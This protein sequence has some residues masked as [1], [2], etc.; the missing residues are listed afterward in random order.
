M[1][2][3]GTHPISIMECRGILYYWVSFNFR[4]GEEE[5]ASVGVVHIGRFPPIFVNHSVP[6]NNSQIARIPNSAADEIPLWTLQPG[7]IK[8]LF[9]VIAIE[10]Q[11]EGDTRSTRCSASK[12]MQGW[13]SPARWLDI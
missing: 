8:L 2:P 3:Y 13:I 10:Q 1:V 11:L 5:L 12:S 7:F 6:G 4:L 9:I